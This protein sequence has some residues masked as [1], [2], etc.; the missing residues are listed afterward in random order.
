LDEE[1]EVQVPTLRLKH[2]NKLFNNYELDVEAQ[3]KQR[4][5]KRSCRYAI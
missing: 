5:A 4:E 2:L 3:D 1:V